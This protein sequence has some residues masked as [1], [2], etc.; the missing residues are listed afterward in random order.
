MASKVET[1]LTERFGPSNWDFAD[2]LNQYGMRRMAEMLGCSRQM[3]YNLSRDRVTK[4][5]VG[6]D[7][8]A[9]S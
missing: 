3:I 4:V 8:D 7:D 5:F 1:R 6:V 9:E 2:A